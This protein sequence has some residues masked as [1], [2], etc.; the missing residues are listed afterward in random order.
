M[1]KA[2]VIVRNH[3]HLDVIEHNEWAIH[4]IQATPEVA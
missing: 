2:S 1:R 4:D 3:S